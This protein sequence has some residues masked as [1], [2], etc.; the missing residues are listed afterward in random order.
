MVFIL[1][2]AYLHICFQFWVCKSVFCII[3]GN[4]LYRATTLILYC[5]QDNKQ[6][7]P[8]PSRTIPHM[9]KTS[10]PPKVK[11]FFLQPP[12]KQ[13]AVVQ[14]LHGKLRYRLCRIF[15]RWNPVQLTTLIKAANVSL[16]NCIHNILPT[17][18]REMPFVEKA[19]EHSTSKNIC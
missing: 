13:S 9:P 12:R 19:K 3:K 17:T 18:Q 15:H 11:S 16:E 4:K 7:K 6:I 1:D 2:K 5:L 14:K 10:Y 8:N